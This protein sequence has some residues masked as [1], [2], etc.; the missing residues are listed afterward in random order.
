MRKNLWLLI[1]LMLPSAVMGQ[2]NALSFNGSSSYAAVSHHADLSFTGSFTIELWFKLTQ[3]P[4]GNYVF[5]GKTLNG[6]KSGWHYG[7]RGNNVNF[8]FDLVDGTG[9]TLHRTAGID[10]IVGTWTHIAYVWNH[11]TSV[12]TVYL[13]GEVAETAAGPSNGQNNNTA[14]IEIGRFNSQHGQYFPGLIDEMRFWN[15]ARTLSQIQENMH[16]TV[17]ASSTGLV[18]YYRMNQTGSTLTDQTTNSHD[19]TVYNTSWASSRAFNTWSGSTSNWSSGS[20]WSLGGFT[21]GDN[22]GIYSSSTSPN[23]SSSTSV[24]SAYIGSSATLTIDAGSDFETSEGLINDGT[25][26]IDA[27][28]SG[29]GQLKVDGSLINNGTIVA[30]Q[31][32]SGS[33]HHSVSSP[34]SN[35]F[36]TTNGTGSALYT[37]N[38]STAA[39]DMSPTL[40]NAGTGFYAP[41]GAS[42]FIT[43]DGT[44]SATGTPNTSHTHTLGYSSSVATGGSGG[45]WNLIGNPYTCGLDWSAVSL[46]NV[47]NAFYIWDP[48]SSAYDYYVSGVSAPTGSYA[49]SSIASAVIPPM[50]AFWVQV[51]SNA[52]ASVVSTMADDGTVASSP[53]FYKTSPDNLILTVSHASDPSVGDVTWIKNVAGTSDGFDGQEDAWKMTNAGVNLYSSYMGDD[54]AVNTLEVGNGKSIDIH[55][56]APQAGESFDIDYQEVLSSG[57]TY[58]VLLEDKLT[59]TYWDFSNGPYSFNHSGW[60]SSDNRFILHMSSSAM[61]EEEDEL[62]AELIVYQNGANI[63]LDIQDNV[64]DKVSVISIDGRLV[65]QYDI[66]GAASIPAPSQS[67]IYI[68]EL[69]GSQEAKRVKLRVKN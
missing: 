66:Q 46:T 10:N 9:A 39:Y 53:A 25:L 41:L 48:S 56:D 44:F 8:F 32:M 64:F 4:T 55:F 57:S 14:A 5:L 34:M 51:S 29:Y 52:A 45:G 43:A 49:G 36:T 63:I 38:A 30:K 47:N 19:G 60:T 67:G 40:T 42:G 31:Y 13:N 28:S 22:I 58:S 20:N 6:S 37:Y 59:G 21:S 17:S 1:C 33:G 35:G 27:S 16:Q 11:S 65:G 12:Y 50:Q 69:L 62:A 54:Y 61:G 7:W 23:V 3:T 68:I 15:V 18:A 2:E 26:T 24:G